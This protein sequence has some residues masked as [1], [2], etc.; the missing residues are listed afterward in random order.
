MHYIGVHISVMGQ[1]PY[2]SQGTRALAEAIGPGYA[3]AAEARYCPLREN[4]WKSVKLQG[5]GPLLT[6]VHIARSGNGSPARLR[7]LE[8]DGANFVSSSMT[9]F[10]ITGERSIFPRGLPLGVA[11]NPIP[12]GINHDP[13]QTPK[14]EDRPNGG[15]A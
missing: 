11:G 9:F 5:R 4:P 6:G 10:D 7:G 2:H 15:S 8:G 14:G 3:L 13:R 1:V 12:R